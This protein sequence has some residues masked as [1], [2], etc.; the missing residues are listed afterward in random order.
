MEEKDSKNNNK[1]LTKFMESEDIYNAD[2]S[3]K[4]SQINNKEYIKTNKEELHIS[5]LI[6]RNVHKAYAL[7]NMTEEIILWKKEYKQ[8]AHERDIPTQN[9]MK[10]E[11]LIKWAN[12]VGNFSME[13][14]RTQGRKTFH[15]LNKRLFSL[16]KNELFGFLNF[17]DLSTRI[18]V[19]E[20]VLILRYIE[21]D[22]IASRD[23]LQIEL[24]FLND[25]V[26]SNQYD[27]VS[28]HERYTNVDGK[29]VLVV[30][31]RISN[32]QAVNHLKL[33]KSKKIKNIKV[34]SKNRRPE[35]N[36]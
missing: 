10:L 23:R 18:S 4:A 27:D 13:F 9:E 21:K 16:I 36:V 32:I 33:E 17:S 22:L 31:V 11:K 34:R 5:D 15:D 28:Y 8:S 2:V 19:G 35:I 30:G 7:N 14:E 1:L 29:D 24:D 26:T 6:K 3:L 12:P 20:D 25:Q